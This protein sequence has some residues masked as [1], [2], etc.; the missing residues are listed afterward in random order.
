MKT[1]DFS[2]KTINTSL[3]MIDIAK[4]FFAVGIV[5][6]HSKL[7]KSDNTIVWLFLHCIFRL[8]VPFFFFV[9][10]NSFGAFGI[11]DL[12]KQNSL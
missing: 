1:S 9:S 2:K 4:F 5:A 7:L 6:I 10:G 3:S 11:S 12:T 8:G